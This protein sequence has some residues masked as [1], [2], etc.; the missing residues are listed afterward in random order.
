[1]K[2]IN[3]DSIWGYYLSVSTFSEKS[4]LLF[5]RWG[6]KNVGGTHVWEKSQIWEKLADEFEFEKTFIWWHTLVKKNSNFLR[7][8]RFEKISALVAPRPDD[9]NNNTTESR[10]VPEQTQSC[11]SLTLLPT[12]KR[13][14][15]CIYSHSVHLKSTIWQQPLIRGSA[16][17]S[18]MSCIFRYCWIIV[19][20]GRLNIRGLRWLHEFTSPRTLNN[21]INGLAK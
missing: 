21:V 18:D 13:Y 12:N 3:W 16:R 4:Q 1:M 9:A 5:L 14:E 19:V 7:N 15:F 8:L 17:D 2:K 20:R 10:L 6:W 11:R